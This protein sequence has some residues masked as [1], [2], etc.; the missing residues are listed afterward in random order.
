MRTRL[1]LA[2][3]AAA[4]LLATGCAR[5]H[6]QIAV[7]NVASLEQSWPKFQ[8]YAN[9]LQANFVAIRDSKLKPD[10]KRRQFAQLSQ[11]SLRWQNEVSN[12]VRGAVQ[13]I[14]SQRNY[15][16]VVTRQGVAFGG[17][18]ITDDVKAAL[19]IPLTSPSP[20]STK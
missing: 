8:N 10:E 12:D 9:Q 18:D 3:F 5:H 11:Q 2:L 20:G 1:W 14:A 16:I 6:S 13:N 4:P 7:V 19:K 15:Q 17:E